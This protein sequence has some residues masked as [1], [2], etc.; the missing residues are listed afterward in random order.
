MEKPFLKRLIGISHSIVE[1]LNNQNLFTESNLSNWFSS[2][3]QMVI[4]Q[5]EL[6]LLGSVEK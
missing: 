2:Y 6:K 4:S 3:F 5:N 1:V